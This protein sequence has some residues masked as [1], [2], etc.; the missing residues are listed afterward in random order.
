MPRQSGWSMG[1]TCYT[2]TMNA[3]RK[4]YRSAVLTLI[5]S[6]V[7]VG[8]F[9]V[10]YAFSKAGSLPSIFYLVV[11]AGVQ[12]LQHLYYAE[13]AIACPEP[14]R[15]VGLVER[16]LGRHFKK[17][18]ATAII[19]GF[20]GALLAYMIVGG[21]FLHSLLSPYLGGIPLMY[22]MI[23]AVL[24]ASVVYFGLAF[25]TRINVVVTAGMLMTMFAILLMGAPHVRLSNYLPLVSGHDLLLPYGILLFS[26]SGLPAILEMEDILKGRHEHYRKAVIV[27]T[28]SAATLIAAFSFT[29][30]GVTGS[31]T[32]TEAVRGLQSVLGPAIAVAGAIA[33]LLAVTAAFFAS[34]INLQSTFRYDYKLSRFWSWSL[35]VLPPFTLLLLGMKDFVTVIS[36]TGAVFSGTSAIMVALLYVAV[37]KKHKVTEKPLGVPVWVAYVSIVLLAI[38][39]L[40][41]L[42]RLVG[43]LI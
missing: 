10:P 37:T 34:A 29:V 18:A 36:F 31:A 5:G 22:Q 35:T 42:A 4:A 27:G 38:G 12:L 16:Y 14:L 43:K 24:G 15:L 21:T 7:G 2:A 41:T 25:V 40:L 1:T 20:W 8:I 23:W 9:G 17:V 39:A 19:L 11:L 13:A 30:L 28:L 26:L 33:G 3:D 32:T 6:I